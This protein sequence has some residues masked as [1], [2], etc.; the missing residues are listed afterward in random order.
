[1]RK[2]G[3]LILIFA[4][5]FLFLG[6]ENFDFLSLKP[7]RVASR[8]PAGATVVAKV[9]DLY[10]TSQDLDKEVEAFNAKMDQEGSPKDK[11]DTR[12]KKI[13]FL[14][15]QLVYRY[16]L[17][18]EALD[19]GIDRDP[20]IERALEYTKMQLLVSKVLSEELQ[21][22]DVSDTEVA[23]FYNKNK[24]ALREPEQRKI[25]EIVTNTEDEAKQAYAQYLTSNDFSGAAKQFSKAS[26]AYMKIKFRYI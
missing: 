5:I 12:D 13:S 17:Y 19:K 2:Y 20:D 10:I 16:M 21:K 7:K 15:E 25:S 8:P 9:G 11:I 18:Q 22:I 24:E 3:N 23:D 26:S 4:A 6:C 14:R 1:M